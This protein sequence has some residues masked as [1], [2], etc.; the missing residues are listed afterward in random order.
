VLKDQGKLDEAVTCYGNALS[1]KPDFAEA[2]NNLGTVLQA[3]GRLDDAAACYRKALLLKPDVAET[4]YNLGTVLQVQG[5]LGEATTRYR[6]ALSLKPD[7]PEAHNDLGNAL[8][9]LGQTDAAVAS[10]QR[11]LALKEAPEFKVNFARS[12][13]R[14]D[15]NHVDADV[16]RLVTRALSEPWARPGDLATAGIRML[17]LDRTMRGFIER[18]S[19]AWPTRL[20][21]RE[22][23]GPSGRDAL[24]DD[25]LLRSLLEN[26]PICDLALERLLTM[27]RH[28]MLDVAMSADVHD[29]PEDK[30]LI[31]YC[32]LARQC[33]INDFVFSHTDEE[34]QRATLLQEKLA[35]AMR[36]GTPIPTL[37][38]VAVGAYFPLVSLPVAEDLL[39]RS[40][41]DP[42]RALL[43]QQVVEPLKERQYR[44]DMT[45]LTAVDNAMSRSVQQQYE[46]NPYPRWVKLPP[47]GEAISVNAYLRQRFP[48]SRFQ[49][50]NEGD[51]VDILIAGCGTGRES[52]EMARQFAGA[53]VLAIDLSLSSLAYAKRKTLEIGLKNI[54]Y[55]QGD[56][57]KLRS[58]GR[59]FD[60]ISAVGVLHHLADP[61]AGWRELLSLLRPGGLMVLG[62]YSELAR[63]S[64]VAARKFIAEHGYVSS[65]A[66]IRR[67]RQDLM[68]LEDDMQVKQVTSFND[69]YVTSECRD[70]LFH[71]QEHRFTLPR[72][73]EVL[74]ELA[75]NLLGF[76]LEPHVVREYSASFPDDASRTTLDYWNDF[77]TKFPKTFAG[78]YVFLVQKPF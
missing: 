6:V 60:I 58:I 62:L 36:L 51:D 3:Q 61:V 9:E 32:A 15:L 45:R 68:S 43:I 4:H 23:F 64:V 16:R 10:Y 14:M 55:A 33:C 24:A 20:G 27:V 72:I 37:W 7:Y 26:C 52:I 25:L 28:A 11:A 71:V 73:K 29:V 30:S 21:S 50:L 76:F 77:E 39:D 47:P 38:I 48:A 13:R 59:S 69:F 78:M 57:M 2:F 17:G 22:L 19:K 8:S 35:A 46:E 34:F 67:C 49:P 63:Q 65:A 31:L 40:W 75:L 12:I 56:L 18:V 1:A 41:P 5:A 42:V 44:A 54:E 74:G 70:L 66:N 53:Q